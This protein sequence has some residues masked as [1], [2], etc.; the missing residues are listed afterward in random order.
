MHHLGQSDF[1]RIHYG[2][3]VILQERTILSCM[4]YKS[5]LASCIPS[6]RIA[7]KFI[8][9]VL[10]LSGYLEVLIDRW[11]TRRR[12]KHRRSKAMAQR[13]LVT[14]KFSGDENED[15][16]LARLVVENEYLDCESET[17]VD[18]AMVRQADPDGRVKPKVKFGILKVILVRRTLLGCPFRMLFKEID[19]ITTFCH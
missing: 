1:A 7:F 16:Q 10:H 13:S 4:E 18:V 19:R 14:R 17:Y 5:C 9:L 12:R 6:K 8:I 15:E 2:M 11:M 3:H